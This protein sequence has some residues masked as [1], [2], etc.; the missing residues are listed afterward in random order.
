[1]AQGHALGGGCE[2]ACFCD[3]VVAAQG[4]RFGQPEIAVG[5]FP[6]VAAALFPHLIGARRAAEL[7][8]TGEAIPADEAHRIGLINAVVPP[9][10]L[11]IEAER[12]LARLTDK[13]AAVLR[14][15]RRA[16]RAGMAAGFDEALPAIEAMYTGSLMQLADPSEGLTAFMQKRKPV[17]KHR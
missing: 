13:S 12:M 1:V 11:A 3:L 8:L 2:L 9:E 16:L 4:A 7:I 15:A 5:V 14:V 17:W 6:P 10:Q